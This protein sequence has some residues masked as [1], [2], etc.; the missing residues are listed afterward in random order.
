M[1][2]IKDLA[3]QLELSRV[4]VSAILND[5]YKKL[6]ISEKTA[7][8]VRA[9]AQSM[10]YLPNQNALS[11]KNGRSMTLGL[12]SSALSE[13]WGAKILI[14]AL[15]AVK[16]TPYS[17]RIEAVQGATEE[18]QALESLLG[19]R[20]EGLF[21]CNINPT[22]ETDAFFKTATERYEVAVASTNCAFSFPHTRVE[23]DN[24]GALEGLMQHL[25]E[26]GHQHIAHIGGD[27]ISEASRER[28]E[29]FRKSVK[30]LHLNP[31]HCPVLFSDWDSEK[32]YE[33]AQQL[34]QAADRP[35]AITC[36]NDTIAAAVLKVAQ[37]LK[38]P[39][40]DALSVVGMSNERISTLTTPEI[41]TVDLPAETIGHNGITALIEAIENREKNPK[42]KV[43]RI[44]YSTLIR[45]S[46]GIVI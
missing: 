35:T 12:I 24:F 34:L 38:I 2:R 26:L 44:T 19:S 1:I 15:S 45:K 41:T 46:T 6:G 18:K 11:M 25:T 14:G 20:I 16:N 30:S 39:V 40:P 37:A 13:G 43:E 23:S 8:R 5:R 36:A 42:N 33:A 32:A 29:A 27:Q 4:T 31:S 9:A 28:A 22:P 21:C 10:G 17:L 3:T 7:E